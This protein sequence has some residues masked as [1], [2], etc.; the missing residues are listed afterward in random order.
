M[1]KII[2]AALICL[3][4]QFT[5]AETRIKDIAAIEG[6]REN[7][8]VGHGLVVGLSG[9]G[10]N[11]K[12]AVFT[13]KGLTDFLERLGVNVQGA[14]IKTKNIAAVTV[15]ASLPPFSR[16]G[17]R[18]DIKV[19]ALGDA[20]SLKGGTLLATPL[21]GADGN[22]YAVAQG[23]VALAEFTPA[24]AD[25]KTKNNSVETNGYIQSGAIVESEVDFN[26]S[27]LE[28]IKFS[29]YSPDFSTAIAVAEA[30]NNH[31][32]GNTAK[33]LDAATIEVVVPKYR[34]NNM[35]DFIAEVERLNVKP[36]YRA[37]IVINEST[38]TVVI[39]DKVHIRP[40]A[41]AQGNLVVNVGQLDF[42][43]KFG[44]TTAEDKR[45]LVNAFVDQRRGRALHQMN[46]GATLSELVSG[47]NKL[48]VWPR[49]IINI[50]HN[51]KSVGALDAVIEV[52]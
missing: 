7:L 51:M 27:D 12:N 23:A 52:R 48:G 18:I 1:K 41:I 36:D 50:L 6:V 28:N 14:T 19:S 26:F 17:N 31:V 47:L 16:Q 11:L 39:G 37:K 46:E 33:A 29:L 20:K 21:L 13:E 32:P 15:T 3:S 22:V 8:L 10:D 4:T 30:I 2:T 49:D 44:P 9:T 40:V 25:V 35:I 24:S 5:F 45:D 38:G 34:E 42:D 43:N